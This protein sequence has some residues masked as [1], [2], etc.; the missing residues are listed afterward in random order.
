[1]LTIASAT[2]MDAPCIVDIDPYVPLA[3]KTYPEVLPGACYFRIGNFRTSLLEIGI[4]PS[5]LIIRS[6]CLVSLDKVREC[7]QLHA[8]CG[9]DETV[10]L[11]VV[12]AG[13]FS[14]ARI[15][16]YRD[17]SVFLKD[18]SFVIDWSDER[19][20]SNVIRFQRVSFCL[21]GD[22]LRRIIFNGLSS[23][24]VA[25]LTKHLDQSKVANG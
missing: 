25:L 16:E 21:A 20:L 13:S 12:D 19:F 22:E 10:G 23:A 9:L 18:D 24:E 1:M 5:S 15:D 2:Q 8:L 3:F 14:G 6:I 7:S 17:F 4:D 11:P